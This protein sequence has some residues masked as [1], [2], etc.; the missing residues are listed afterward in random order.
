MGIEPTTPSL[1][2]KCSATE[3]LG[4]AYPANDSIKS[5]RRQAGNSTRKIA[6]SMESDSTH[7]GM[8]YVAGGAATGLTT[9][10][11]RV[12]AGQ[13]IMLTYS[14]APAWTWFGD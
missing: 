3:L 10:A 9:G 13:T 2:W 7:D 6:T 11:V 5:V 12:P 14:V 8:V 1:P 4:R